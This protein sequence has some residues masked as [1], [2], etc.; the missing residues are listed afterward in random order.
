VPINHDMVSR[1]FIGSPCIFFCQK[2]YNP[3]EPLKLTLFTAYLHFIPKN[4][5]LTPFS[6]RAF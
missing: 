3:E 5:I 6:A 1:S 2:N 4:T